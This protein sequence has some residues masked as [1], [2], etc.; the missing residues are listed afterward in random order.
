VRPS[1]IASE[2]KPQTG[3][4]QRPAVLLNLFL[5]GGGGTPIRVVEAQTRDA[6]APV[7]IAGEVIRVIS[8]PGSGGQVVTPEPDSA[9]G[10]VSL[11]CPQSQ[12]AVE[13]RAAA[14]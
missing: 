10:K 11:T 9:C 13:W 8:E 12:L 5:G 2:E 4:S 6:G 7:R 14:G 3:E 1:H